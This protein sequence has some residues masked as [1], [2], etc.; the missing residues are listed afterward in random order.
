MTVINNLPY[1]S[2]RTQE[3][4]RV[5]IGNSNVDLAHYGCLITCISMASH[6]FGQYK[7]PN[8]IATVPGL[9]SND[10]SLIWINLHKAFD[11]FQFRWREGNILSGA[12]ARN[13]KLI[14][15]Y[16]PGGAR[17]KDGVVILAVAN[18]TH[19]ILPIWFDEYKQ[20]YKCIDPWDGREVYAI[21]RYKS[22][23]A[24]A[25]LLKTGVAKNK[26]QPEAPN[27]N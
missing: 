1:L 17:T 22:I 12:P 21:E 10:G 25:H 15:A 16:L 18:N 11:K 14:K 26:L 8:E 4:A 24:H 19:W 7:L 23:S 5:K 27:F 20:D 9:F 13:D 3:W 6:W 2:Q